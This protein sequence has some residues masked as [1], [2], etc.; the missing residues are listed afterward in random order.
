MFVI[1]HNPL[2]EVEN[3]EDGPVWAKHVVHKREIR[4]CVYVYI[5]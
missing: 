2:I 4:V 1:N 5:Y 3:N